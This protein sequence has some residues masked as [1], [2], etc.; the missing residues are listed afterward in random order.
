MYYNTELD[1]NEF[2]RR[3]KFVK[4]S[5]LSTDNTV[6]QTP[7]PVIDCLTQLIF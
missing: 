2:K 3:P 4:D 6:Y 7:S 1:F 5:T